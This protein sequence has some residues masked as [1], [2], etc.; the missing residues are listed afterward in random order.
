[1]KIDDEPIRYCTECGEEIAKISPVTGLSIMPARYKK[2]ERC[3]KHL[4]CYSPV[5]RGVELRYCET[6]GEPISKISCHGRPIRPDRYERRTKCAL[7]AHDTS[8]RRLDVVP[9]KSP[10]ELILDN[11]L[12]GAYNGKV[13]GIK[14]QAG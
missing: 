9:L 8:G 6:C 3:P 11:F 13:H 7:H 5:R 10:Q 1:M 4:K 12:R 14:R 2:K